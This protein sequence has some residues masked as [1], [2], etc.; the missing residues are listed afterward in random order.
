MCLTL[1]LSGMLR[2][3]GAEIVKELQEQIYGTNLYM[4][5]VMTQSESVIRSD[6]V[7]DPG[8]YLYSGYHWTPETAYLSK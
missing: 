6:T 3:E 5:S 4:I 2:G 8:F 1:T 7:Q